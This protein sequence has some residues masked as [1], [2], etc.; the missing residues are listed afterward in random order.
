MSD[1]LTE[2]NPIFEAGKCYPSKWGRCLIE[3]IQENGFFVGTWDDGITATCHMRDLEP[4][5][6]RD[7]T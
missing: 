5:E 7:L 1:E 2:W 6:G 3:E 4:V